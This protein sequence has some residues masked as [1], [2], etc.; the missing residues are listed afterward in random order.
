MSPLLPLATGTVAAEVYAVG[1]PHCQN[2]VRYRAVAVTA[3][4]LTYFDVDPISGEIKRTANARPTSRSN[5]RVSAVVVS[6]NVATCRRLHLLL[7]VYVILLLF[8]LWHC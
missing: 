5:W 3:G 2:V 6:T 4:A 1:F 7:Y 8:V